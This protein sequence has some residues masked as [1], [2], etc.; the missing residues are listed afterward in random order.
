MDW[1]EKNGKVEF[2]VKWLGYASTEN[3]WEPP[4]NL[5]RFGSG[6]KELLLEFISNAS[7]DRLK[8]L[9]P[10]AYGG[11]GVARRRRRKAG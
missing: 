4:A 2:E 9:L 10:K 8:Q 1:R 7:G 5:A 11:I 6:A 3:T